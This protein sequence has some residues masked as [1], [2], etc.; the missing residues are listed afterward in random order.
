MGHTT[1]KQ[2]DILIITNKK[3]FEKQPLFLPTKERTENA[4]SKYLL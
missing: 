4:A 1:A 2:S 3:E